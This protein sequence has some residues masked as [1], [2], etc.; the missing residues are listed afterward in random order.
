MK[1]TAA[2]AF[3]VALVPL[4]AYAE[5]SISE[6]SWMG[7]DTSAN[8]EWIELYNDGGETVSLDEWT[9]EALD[10]TPS[11]TLSGAVSANSFFL[12]ERTDDDTVP[13][14]PADQIYTGAL[15]NDG[16]ALVL[17]KA[18]GE[19]ESRVDA[20]GGWPAGDNITK[21]TMQWDSSA[22][23]T[24]TGTPKAAFVPSPAQKDDGTE[25]L[26]SGN[27]GS[28]AP[29]SAGIRLSPAN[30][31]FFVEE[32]VVSAGHDRI[33]TPG[34]PIAFRAGAQD[35]SGGRANGV[36]F[37]W[38]FGDGTTG[39]G[40]RVSHSYRYAGEY[41]VVLNAYYL[42]SEAV[43]RARVSV[44]PAELA[45]GAHR[46]ASDMIVIE[47]RSSYEV[48]LGG[49][50]LS[51]REKSFEIPSSTVVGARSSVTFS[52]ALFGLPI[53]SSLSLVDPAGGIAAH[54]EEPRDKSSSKEV[55]VGRL[56]IELATA[57]RELKSVSGKLAELQKAAPPKPIAPK[58]KSD[59]GIP[60]TEVPQSALLVE[61]ITIENDNG[62]FQ[63]I[64]GVPVRVFQFISN[65]FGGGD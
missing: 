14:V 32:I 48:N 15:G 39:S 61:T 4:S 57:S 28:G 47:N 2:L 38:S 52:R 12:L 22:W 3:L 50:K 35:R 5:V 49:W 10:G 41:I 40:E 42:G 23:V 8:D 37:Q 21:E 45:F 64:I 9:L 13:G 30:Q 63:K 43:S 59:P 31:N 36:S 11:I 65:I 20:S 16:E 27:G 18:G 54:E 51:G 29:S 26:Q 58:P 33:A 1:K 6:I 19:E 55:E 24:A 56:S 60:S 34:A 25:A 7:T 17:K 44:V 62:L 46:A 53:G